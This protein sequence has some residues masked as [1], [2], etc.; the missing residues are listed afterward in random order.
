MI[1]FLIHLAIIRIE[2]AKILHKKGDLD[3]ELEV[4]QNEVAS[5]SEPLGLNELKARTRRQIAECFVARG[6]LQK[7]LYPSKNEVLIFY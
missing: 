2:Y 5:L 1:S 3:R 7:P 6:E 4:L